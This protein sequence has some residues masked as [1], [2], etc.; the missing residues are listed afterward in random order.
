MSINE[1]AMRCT[2]I[3]LRA[4]WQDRYTEVR[5]QSEHV[6]APLQ[7]EGYVIQTM[8]NVSPPK[9]HLAHILGSS[10]PFY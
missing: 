6:C 7:S 8:P 1:P 3:L 9:W 4:H 10:K 2:E 5:Q